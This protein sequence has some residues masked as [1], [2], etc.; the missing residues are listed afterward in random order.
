MK[1]ALLFSIFYFLISVNGYS[2]PITWY[3]TWGLPGTQR[4]EQGIRVCQTFDGG[5]AILVNVS[6]VQNNA[7]YDL[8]KYDYL[9]N[10]QWINVIIDSTNYN[11]VLNDMQQT[12]DS[13]FIFAGYSTGALLIK[14][15]KNGNL[16]WQRNYTNLNSGTH[17]L[18]VKQTRDK[19][20][21]SCGNYLDYVN[22]S[23]KGIVI[24][25]DS[26]GFVQWEKQYMDSIHNSYSGIIQGLDRNYYI[27]G[28]TFNNQPS[29]PYSVLKKLDTLGNV[30][31]T[32]LFYSNGGFGSI[33]Q[34]NDSSI[35]TGGKDITTFYPLIAKFFPS[36]QIKWLH[37]YPTNYEFYFYF[38][39]KDMFDNIL[40][41]GSFDK[42]NYSTIG[43]WKLDTSG[44]ILEIKEVEYSG[45]TMIGA[46]CIKPTTDSGYILT[47][48]IDLLGGHDA[49]IIKTDSAFN[50]PLITEIHNISSSVSRGFKI[51]QNY[52]NPFNSTTLIKFN[53]SN[54]GFINFSIYD[55]LGKKIFSSKEYRLKG[56]NEKI[57]NLS[58]MNL[59]SGIYFLKI[60]FEL[61]S[62]L[63]KLVYLK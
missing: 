5:Y 33:I 22:P 62:E 8:L 35:I 11:R 30:L 37:N 59:S 20:Y 47:G 45:Y 46:Y 12:S 10:L 18:E 6:N 43:N 2:Q 34:L 29:I 17:F 21:I 3:R 58:N 4:S 19:G 51:L 44:T 15:D 9:G 24:K 25:V 50:C 31:N 7:W 57:I 48:G 32:N 14:T 49:L 52:P 23:T 56:L 27:V 41:T 38:M 42:V 40:M 60:N 26:L 36:G 54:N 53:V 13:G 61:N 28:G 39:S 1:K 63:I 16:K 55:L